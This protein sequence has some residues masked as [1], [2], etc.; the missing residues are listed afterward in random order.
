MKKSAFTMIELVFVIVVLGILAAVAL[1]RL[2]STMVSS[3]IAAA[4]GDVA[5]VRS[6][7]ASERQ[8]NLVKGINDYP[9]TLES[10]TGIFGAVLT[11]PVYLDSSAGWTDR[12]DM[13]YTNTIDTGRTVEFTYDPDTGIFDCD[14]GEDDCKK[15]VE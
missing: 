8:K 14:H 11:Y 7:I 2:G 1:P 3:R 4:Q 10:G 6:A 13:V 15:I 9:T 5:A 12:T